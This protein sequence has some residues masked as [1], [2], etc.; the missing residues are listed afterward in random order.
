MAI[1]TVAGSGR[2]AVRERR[3]E[4]IPEEGVECKL[5]EFKL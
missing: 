2:D 3:I 5:L 4:W 1:I